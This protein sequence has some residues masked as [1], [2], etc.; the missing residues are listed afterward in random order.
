M[1]FFGSI[2]KSHT[3]QHSM[4]IPQAVNPEQFSE[5]KL[6]RDLEELYA[7]KKKLKSKEQVLNTPLSA[8]RP[9]EAALRVKNPFRGR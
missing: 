3:P 9:E 1:A 8:L 4:I 5:E 6:K 7:F 2:F